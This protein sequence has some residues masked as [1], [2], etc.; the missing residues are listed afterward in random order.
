MKIV[1]QLFKAKNQ[2]LSLISPTKAASQAVS[3]FLNPRRSQPKTWELKAETSGQRFKLN[4]QVSAIRWAPESNDR[5]KKQVLLVHGWESRATQMYGFVPKLMQQGY[6]VVAIDMPAHGLSSGVRSDAKQFSES[7]LLAE[8]K[9]G[10]FDIIIAHSMGAGATSHALAN[11]LSSDK[12]VLISTASSIETVLNRFGRYIGLNAKATQSFVN[13][14]GEEVGTKAS[15]IDSITMAQ[16]N[17]IPTLFIHDR[18]DYEVPL[19]EAEKLLPLFNNSDIFITEGLGHRKIL[20]SQL[21]MD[22]INSFVLSTSTS[23]V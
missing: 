17:S 22:K 19:S 15:E 7:I 13:Q 16:S 4:Q 20:K 12:L 5:Q 11:G 2:L 3:I 23:A 14:V 18:F 1:M 10:K 21:V 8:R 9:C 6:E